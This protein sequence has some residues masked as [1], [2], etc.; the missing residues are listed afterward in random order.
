LP[1]QQITLQELYQLL[2]EKDVLLYQLQ[3][4]LEHV[5]AALAAITDKKDND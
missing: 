4:E 3:R 1:N 5:K 2:G